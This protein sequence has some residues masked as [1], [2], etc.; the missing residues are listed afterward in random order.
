MCG[1]RWVLQSFYR[2]IPTVCNGF[3]APYCLNIMVRYVQAKPAQG[4]PVPWDVLLAVVG[5]TTIP[6]IQVIGDTQNLKLGRRLG[7]RA[8]AAL[9]AAVYR[10]A[11]RVKLNVTARAGELNNLISVSSKPRSGFCSWAVCLTVSHISCRAS[12][13]WIQIML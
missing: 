4:T 8:R 3:V 1:W 13:R 12:C 9:T 2:V 10:K 6:V 5:I 7:M 11:M